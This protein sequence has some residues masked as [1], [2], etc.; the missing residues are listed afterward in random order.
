[1]SESLSSKVEEKATETNELTSDPMRLVLIT[2][3]LSSLTV[4]FILPHLSWVPK[5]GRL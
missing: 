1:M 3:V 4:E 2:T 5:G